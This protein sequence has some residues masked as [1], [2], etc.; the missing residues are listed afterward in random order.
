LE[1]RGGRPGR[2]DWD[3]GAEAQA[4]DPQTAAEPSYFPKT[5]AFFFTAPRD[6]ARLF[7]VALATVQRRIERQNGRRASESD[8]LEAI[9]EH[10]F[11]SWGLANARLR[12][13]HRVFA[14]DGWRCTFPGCTSYG[15]LHDHHVAYRSQGGSD[16]LE[17]RT[18]LC[19]W[20]HQRGEHAKRVRCR[21]RAPGGRRFEL[22]C[23]PGR[24][25]LARYRSGDVLVT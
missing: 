17:N 7:R 6:V 21:G 4:G 9:L 16:E 20:H 15:N 23:A 13:E 12:R 1:Q 24:A 3:D 2:A 10:A 11:G 14:R 22:G 25:P 5:M 18:T 8:A 19:A